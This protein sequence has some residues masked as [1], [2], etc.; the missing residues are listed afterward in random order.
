[1]KREHEETRAELNSAQL[2]I[3]LLQTEVSANEHIGYGSIK[4]Q[5]PIQSNKSDTKKTKEDRWIEVIVGRQ[6]RTKQVE[7]DPGKWQVEVKHHY[8]LLEDQQESSEVA[9]S[10]E[11]EKIRGMKNTSRRFLKKKKHKVILIGD[12][13]ARGCADKLSNYLGNSYEVWRLEYKFYSEQP[14]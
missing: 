4:S 7:I 5:N 13:H 3:K 6:R 9:D 11:L 12:S 1:L 2:I 14:T 8:K 10:L